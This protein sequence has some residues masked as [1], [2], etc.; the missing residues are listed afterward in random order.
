M[1]KKVFIANRGLVAAN[2]VRAVRE[3][4]AV[5]AVAYEAADLGSAAV[6]G[7][8]EALEISTDKNIPAYLDVDVI[9]ATAQKCGADAVHPGYGFLARNVELSQ[10]LQEV[11]ITLIGNDLG[12]KPEIKEKAR[13][14]GIAVLPN[15]GILQSW[16]DVD[17][18]APSVGFPLVVKALAS[19]SGW[20]VRIVHTPEE[21]RGSYEY[22]CIQCNKHGVRQDVMLEKY[23][24]KAHQVEIP[25]LRDESGKTLVLPEIDSTVQ[26]RFQKLLVESPSP[27]VSVKLRGQMEALIASLAKKL[28][29]IG[30][31]TVE[32][33]VSEG[34]AYMIDVDSC[35]Q[36]SHSV[37][38]MY[39]GINVIR[40][41]IR[42]HSGESLRFQS[43][44][45]QRKGHAMGIFL[46]AMDPYRKFAPSPGRIDRFH[47]PSGEGI[48]LQ[49]AVSS[50]DMVSPQYDPLI[51][52]IM[53]MDSTREEAIA[54]MA[55]ALEDCF[56][57]GIQT[58]LPMMRAVLASP[59]FAKA[60]MSI[61]TLF[62]EDKRIELLRALRNHRDD[63]IACVVAA[64]ALNTDSNASQILASA[65]Q[66]NLLWSMA[67]RMMNRKKMD[68]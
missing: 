64:L 23:L 15:T 18:A 28:N 49:S 11:G 42:L 37:T 2:C 30:Y 45:I 48:L 54:R 59:D 9:V 22:V 6:R 33:L 16:N 35:M 3:L 66:G 65:P 13:Q 56:I 61:S 27:A 53:V 25:V 8:D 41:Q 17:S 7:A 38:S 51:A 14:S 20:G 4:G 63:E 12:T 24:E 31:A 29:L 34:E 26:R 46:Y 43:D 39:S 21:L 32:F 67:S 57:D 58:T 55:N 47:T 44:Q 1:F 50:G 5:A 40:E 36:A 68:F 52:K 19:Y 60:K 10:K 62:S